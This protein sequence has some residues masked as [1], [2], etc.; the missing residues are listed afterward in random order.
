MKPEYENRLLNLPLLWIGWIE[1]VW[2]LINERKFCVHKSLKIFRTD[3]FIKAKH[4]NEKEILKP[5]KL[6]NLELQ[7]RQCSFVNGENIRQLSDSWRRLYPKR[8]KAANAFKICSKCTTW[9]R[10][11]SKWRALITWTEFVW[12]IKKNVLIQKITFC[13]LY[14]GHGRAHLADY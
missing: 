4:F 5:L 10:G 9:H 8:F 12:P 1:T 14:N 7:N 6:D 13:A 3:Q 11:Y 2:T